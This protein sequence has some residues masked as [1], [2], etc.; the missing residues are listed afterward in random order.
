METPARCLFLAPLSTR[1]PLLQDLR[2]RFDPLAE[3][4]QPHVT[5]LPPF[6]GEA[7]LRAWR[8]LLER[9]ACALPIVFSLG[10]PLCRDGCCFFP[11]DQ[12]REEVEALRRSIRAQVF[13]G[14]RETLPFLPHL[15]FGRLGPGQDRA[16]L[17]REA[18]SLLPFW[19]LLDSLVLERIGPREESLVEV[20]F[21]WGTRSRGPGLG[22]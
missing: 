15:T 3:K 20:A 8:A 19:G 22:G 5:L 7:D 12:G 9:K 10:R 18:R 21:P 4:L 16:G 2:G 11:L 1:L 14:E 6:R 13:P 17:L